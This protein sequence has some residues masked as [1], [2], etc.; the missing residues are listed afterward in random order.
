MS[1]SAPSATYSGGGVAAASMTVPLVS[2]QGVLRGLHRLGVAHG[3]GNPSNLI[4]SGRSG[5]VIELVA[6]GGGIER[7][8]GYAPADEGR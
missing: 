4:A 7:A 1:A 5:E 3:D 8:G 2:R 6:V